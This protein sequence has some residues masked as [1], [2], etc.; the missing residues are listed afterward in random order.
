MTSYTDH[1]CNLFSTYYD[2]TT[3]LVVLRKVLVHV[4]SV[5]MHVAGTY[6]RRDAQRPY[7]LCFSSLDADG[8]RIL[9]SIRDMY[10]RPIPSPCRVPAFFCLFVENNGGAIVFFLSAVLCFYY[11]CFLSLLIFFLSLTFVY[12]RTLRYSVVVCL[13]V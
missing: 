1:L 7:V 2:D 8:S 6:G 5:G 9:E 12:A 11:F 4:L 13:R 3:C 10:P